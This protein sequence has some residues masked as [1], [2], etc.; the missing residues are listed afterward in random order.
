MNKGELVEAIADIM[1]IGRYYRASKSSL[2][3]FFTMLVVGALFCGPGPANAANYSS[4][5]ELV[6]KARLTIEK[7]AAHPGMD[8]FRSLAKKAKAIFIVPQILRGAFFLG[9]AGGSG[10][11]L[12]R[13][14]ATGKWSQPT[15]YTIGTA[16]FGLQIGGDVSEVVFVVRT[17]KGLEEFYSSSIRLGSD[18]SVAAGPVG[19][20]TGATGAFKAKSD[21]VMFS[22]NKGVYGGMSLK[23]SVIAFSDT[24]NRAYYGKNVRPIDILVRANASNPHSAAL[25]AAVTKIAK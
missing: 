7:F 10:V 4:Q 9:G 6:E 12:V 1:S 3:A 22:S 23:G 11:L 18:F 5:Q 14:Q 8:Y 16:S 17:A 24:S 2:I 21:L 25:R 15:F 20:G 19:V 13:E